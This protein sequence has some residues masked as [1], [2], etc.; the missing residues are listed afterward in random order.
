MKN[1]AHSH[2][3]CDIDFASIR[4][5]CEGKRPLT[6]QSMDP[7]HFAQHRAGAWPAP[8]RHG[9]GIRL[10]DIYEQVKETGLPNMLAARVPL[11]SNLNI[12][13]WERELS[14][15]QADLEL[16]SLI[17]FGFPLG[18][19]GPVSESNKTGN[20]KSATDFPQDIDRFIDKEITL[21]GIIGPMACQPFKEWCHISPLMT[22]EKKDSETRRVIIDMTFP[23][24]S[25]V[26]AY[27]YKNTSLGV[28]RDHMLPSVDIVVST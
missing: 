14:S 20:H 21:G 7:R 2:L 16:L 25:S 18:Y 15:S 28:Q 24:E 5:L 11:P 10:S 3:T 13:A 19:A 9:M 26:N 6:D 8:S 12:G 17:N 22:R 27:I 1:N 4:S 23:A